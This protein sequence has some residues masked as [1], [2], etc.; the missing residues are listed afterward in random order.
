MIQYLTSQ[1]QKYSIEELAQMAIE[2]GCQW[3]QLTDSL[4][5]DA[6]LRDVAAQLQELCQESETILIIDHD[7]E[8]VNEL[9]VFGVHLGKGDMKPEAAREL[10][11]P[12]AIIGVDVTTPEEVILLQPADIDYVVLG[13]Y[14]ESLSVEQCGKFIKLLRDKGNQTAVVVR[15]RIYDNDIKALSAVGINGFAVSEAITDAD[16]PVAATARL[17]KTATEAKEL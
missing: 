8:L 4:P 3:I 14:P 11:G 9:K 6:S 5:E 2:G 16:D 13:G 1:S 17:I 7:V 10:L 12:H 15:G